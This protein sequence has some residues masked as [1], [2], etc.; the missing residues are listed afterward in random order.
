MSNVEKF[1]ADLL[2]LRT[3]AVAKSGKL[4]AE[5]VRFMNV[6]K[7]YASQNVDGLLADAVQKFNQGELYLSEQVCRLILQ[8]VGNEIRAL[9]LLATIASRLGNHEDA[10]DLFLDC[11]DINP[12]LPVVRYELASAFFKSGRFDLALDQCNVLLQFERENIE[13]AVLKAGSLVK[14]GQYDA[15]LL[16][17][18]D[19]LTTRPEDVPVLLRYGLALRIVGRAPEAVTAFRKAI[20]LDSN[21]GEAYWNLANLKIFKFEAADVEKM[22]DAIGGKKLT[23]MNRA[24]FL[25][26]LGKAMNDSGNFD[27]AFSYFTEAN[28]LVK[29]LGKYAPEDTSALVDRSIETFSKEYFEAI[30]GGSASDEPIFIVGLPRSGSTLLE[31]V[32]SSHSEVDATMEL[33]EIPAMARSLNNPQ[34]TGLASQYPEMMNDLQGPDRER[35]GEEYLKRTKAFRGKKRMFID[36]TPSNF[37]HIGLIASIL[38][39]A[40]IIDARRDPIACGL[41]I[42]TQFFARGTSFSYDLEHIGHYYSDYLRLMNH[43]H[44]VLPGKILTVQYE[45]VVG[46]IESEVRK[47]LEFCGLDFEAE[48]LEFYK[49]ERAVATVS[50]EQVRQ[51]VYIS[52]LEHWR[53]YGQYL[54]PLRNALTKAAS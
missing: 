54:D 53:N 13:Y 40:K 21:C 33:S 23:P 48:C 2:K 50:S 37:L 17:Y 44:E 32:L 36:K 28:E 20:S 25:F 46:D 15:A 42:Y 35:L 3:L 26:S 30:K 16:A 45:N 49:S 18:E 34:R 5:T 4:A 39:K 12:N 7:E 51:P 52:S 29:G 8:S 27:R 19:V 22:E 43:W 10:V 38:P 47:V 11:L 6:Y 31:Q 1:E 9:H 41:S 14:L 24:Y